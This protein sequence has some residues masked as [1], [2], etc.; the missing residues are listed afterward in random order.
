VAIPIVLALAL[1]AW[2]FAADAAHAAKGKQSK[3]KPAPNVVVI[4]TD[5]QALGTFTDEVMPQTVAKLQ[6]R[7][8]TF[9]QA[10]VSTP[11]CCPS[12]AAFFTGQ[13]A[14]NNGVVSNIPGYPLLDKPQSVLPA[15][16][17]KAGYRTAHIGKF[18]NGYQPAIV[19]APGWTRWR[20]AVDLDYFNPVFSSM[21]GS[22][23]RR[24][25]SPA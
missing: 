9:T 21:A 20:T 4:Q 11:Q 22:R 7:G 24:S 14:H 2:A 13:Y 18:L 19:P 3:P 6:E 10:I 17:Q 16:L 1:C 15:W 12:R 5:D 8:T 25:T 23:S